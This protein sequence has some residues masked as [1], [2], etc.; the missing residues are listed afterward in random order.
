MSKS[1]T[2]LNTYIEAA[3]KL[4][5][6]SAKDINKNNSHASIIISKAAEMELLSKDENIQHFMDKLTVETATEIRVQNGYESNSKAA[7]EQAE[8]IGNFRCDVIGRAFHDFATKSKLEWLYNINLNTQANTN[9]VPI[10]KSE[11]VDEIK[12]VSNG[13]QIPIYYYT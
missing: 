5:T 1:H 11:K 7:Q 2:E 9:F 13:W 8:W 6:Q 3:I 10:P 12:D 4:G